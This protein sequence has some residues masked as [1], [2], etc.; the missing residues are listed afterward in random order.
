MAGLSITLYISHLRN[1]SLA[2]QLDAA[3]TRID[4][5]RAS[6]NQAKLDND[7]LL[8]SA[9]R[10]GEAMAALEQQAKAAD[11]AAVTSMR[12][13]EALASEARQRDLTRRAKPDMP[14]PEEM[15]AATK[16]AIGNL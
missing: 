3:N 4:Q 1:T 6:L 11:S 16:E 10:Q 5:A 14:A 12:R 9:T 15:T 2:H 8:A 7:A 13:A